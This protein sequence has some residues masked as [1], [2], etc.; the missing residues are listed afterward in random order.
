[1]I[2]PTTQD[3]ALASKGSYALSKSG[4]I[5]QRLDNA[6]IPNYSVVPEHSNKD[7][8][9]YKHDTD[10]HFIIAHRGTDLHGTTAGKDLIADANVAI[11]N[12]DG[13]ALH[14]RRVKRT[15]K[16]I[17]ALKKK[18][19][20]VHLTGHSLGA[21]SVNHTLINS[22]IVREHIHHAE[23]FNAGGSPLGDNSTVPND[24]KTLLNAKVIHHRVDG[25]DLS[26]SHQHLIG[27]KKKYKSSTAVS[28]G[29]H[30]LRAVT[31][32]LNKSKIGKAVAYGAD[33]VL[34]VL[35]AHSLNNFTES[36]SYHH[37]KKTESNY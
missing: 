20:D 24:V 9:T 31:P 32:L 25:D 27:K 26:S 15:E 16:I 37:Q 12:E 2:V 14:N 22:K 17:L 1:M 19:G 6:S 4:S 36:N 33:K 34:S 5:A 13:S 3:L 18:G 11:G 35:Q 28:I 8:T 29:K 10:S 23:T 30:I 21:N 7:M